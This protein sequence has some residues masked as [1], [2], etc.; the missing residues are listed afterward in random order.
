MDY[1]IMLSDMDDRYTSDLLNF[2]YSLTEGLIRLGVINRKI[3]I[4]Q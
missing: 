1:N 2:S 4:E 3:K